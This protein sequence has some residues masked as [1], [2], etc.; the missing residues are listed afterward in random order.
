M[1]PTDHTQQLGQQARKAAKAAVAGRGDVRIAVRDLTLHALRSR[2]LTAEHLANVTKAVAEGIAGTAGE[3]FEQARAAT[4]H[5]FTGL[6]EAVSK[7]L[8]A[9]ELSAREFAE[10]SGRLA[11]SEAERLLGEIAALEKTLGEGWRHDHAPPPTEVAERLAA[12]ATHLK[13]AVGDAV[14]GAATLV[15]RDLGAGAREGTDAVAGASRVLGLVASGALLALS[16][17][18]RESAAPRRG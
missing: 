8:L 14:P 4:R 17:A 9:L 2:M 16:E 10:G 13:R 11:P 7:G 3:P 18:L 12:V 5:A 1:A 6:S 15:A